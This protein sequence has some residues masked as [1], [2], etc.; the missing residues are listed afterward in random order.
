[1]GRR[2]SLLLR[3]MQ[4]RGRILP[5]RVWWGIVTETCENQ[6]DACAALLARWRRDAPVSQ[7]R[8]TL[9][10]SIASHPVHS[11]LTPLALLEPLSWLYGVRP[12]QADG[13]TWIARAREATEQF[14]LYYHQAAPFSRRALARLWRRCLEAEPE[15]CARALAEAR[16][17]L[18]ALGVDPTRAGRRS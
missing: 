13:P 12:P 17:A 6:G 9:E 18:E 10:A 16:P 4:Q 7:L 14:R 1:V 11:R 15:A 2:H 8:E 3:W 5:E